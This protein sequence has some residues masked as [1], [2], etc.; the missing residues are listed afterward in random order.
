MKVLDVRDQAHA[1]ASIVEAA[2]V[3]R[4]GGLV[5][6][7]TETVYGLG[8]NAADPAAIR[9]IYEAKGRPSWNPLIVHVAAIEAARE[10]TMR[11]TP[12]AEKLAVAFW[13]GPLTIVLDRAPGVP[14][15]VSAG[16]PS[17]AIRIPNQPIARMLLEAARVPVAAPSANRSTELSP[18]R[19]EHVSR[20]LGDAVDVILDGGPTRVG[21]ESTVVDA[22]GELAVILRPGTIT[23]AQIEA[24]VPTAAGSSV[25]DLH[26][27]SPG[28]MERH[29]APRARLILFEQTDEISSLQSVRTAAVTH[30]LDSIDGVARTVRLPDDALQYAAE[31]YE[32]LH[33]LDQQGFAQI[34]VE[35]PPSGDAWEAV[36][37]RLGRAAHRG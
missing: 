25:S 23:R 9:R 21:I 8:G 3:L 29:Y 7:P 22:T 4:R 18:T 17:I 30:T 34:A 6:F 24:V 20:G 11:F 10:L 2:A 19:A 36:R 31:L 26:R 28:Q 33:E 35:R 37:D 5:A 27:R 13:P 16:L 15:E 32:T 12:L 14:T 1:G